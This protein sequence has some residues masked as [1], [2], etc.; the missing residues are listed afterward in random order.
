M[1]NHTTFRDTSTVALTS[2]TGKI[3][4]N[5]TWAIQPRPTEPWRMKLSVTFT[6]GCLNVCPTTK[7]SF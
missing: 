2:R 3:D 1:L 6:T 4:V 7:G 5:V